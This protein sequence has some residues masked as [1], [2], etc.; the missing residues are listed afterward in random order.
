M[1]AFNFEEFENPGIAFT[2]PFLNVKAVSLEEKNTILYD[3]EDKLF[4]YF[5]SPCCI[6]VLIVS[7]S[8][9]LLSAS[10]VFFTERNTYTIEC[11]CEKSDNKL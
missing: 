6:F 11:G 10:P 2:Y 1:S 5:C 4:V 3:T 7:R 9:K 8:F